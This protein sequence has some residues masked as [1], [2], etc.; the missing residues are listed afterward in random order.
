MPMCM[1]CE[2]NVKQNILGLQWT[3]S[4]QDSGTFAIYICDR[5]N[6]E[7]SGQLELH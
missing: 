2:A 4:T 6:S 1:H 5:N 3:Y 7:F